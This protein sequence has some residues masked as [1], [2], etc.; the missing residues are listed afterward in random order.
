M[1]PV[2]C[3]LITFENWHV[4]DIFSSRRFRKTPRTDKNVL[5][6]VPITG[7][8]PRVMFTFCRPYSGV[9]I[10][11]RSRVT[12]AQNRRPPL[13]RALPSLIINL[14]W[15]FCD[16]RGQYFVFFPQLIK[17]PVGDKTTACR[18]RKSSFTVG[19]NHCNGIVKNRL[20]PINPPP[21]LRLLF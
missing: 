18:R 14:H 3:S 7:L 9:P 15:W 21:S 19:D 16:V 20:I 1:T 10:W 8:L 17:P 4:L 13:V 2:F 11:R 12:D 5:I 6:E